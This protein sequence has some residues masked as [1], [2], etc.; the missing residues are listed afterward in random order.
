MIMSRAHMASSVIGQQNLAPPSHI[1][2]EP[3]VDKFFAFLNSQTIAVPQDKGMHVE[4]LKAMKE[5]VYHMLEKKGGLSKLNIAIM[6]EHRRKKRKLPPLTAVDYNCMDR[7]STK[8]KMVLD[9]LSIVRRISGLALKPRNLAVVYK[10]RDYAIK[11][12]EDYMEIVMRPATIAIKLM[13]LWGPTFEIEPNINPAALMIQAS[14]PRIQTRSNK[15]LVAENIEKVRQQR[16]ALAKVNDGVMKG[17]NDPEFFYNVGQEAS[18][19]LVIPLRRK[20]EVAPP[21]KSV[22]KAPYSLVKRR[23]SSVMF[24]FDKEICDIQETLNC[25]KSVSWCSY[26]FL[27]AFSIMCLFFFMFAA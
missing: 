8:L 26:V 11:L 24:N 2:N 7:A 27:F 6:N 4:L 14:G 23:D 9:T 13:M 19:G 22:M 21:L 1:V 17:E 5:S 12:R 3:I 25:L 10:Q 16:K 18:T 15:S 20:S